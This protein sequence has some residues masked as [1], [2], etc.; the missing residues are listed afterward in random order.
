MG[1]GPERRQ[2]RSIRLPGCD[3]A[4]PGAYFVT[5]CAH[6]KEC[7]FDL[8]ELSDAVEEAWRQIPLHFPN[9]TTDEF[10]VMPNHIHGIL[11]IL[12][13]GAQPAVAGAPTCRPYTTCQAGL[14]GSHR[15]FLQVRCGQ[16]R[17]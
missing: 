12:T 15:A 11:W 16:T 2:R 4:S 8:P 7:I 10:I 17:Q 14:S 6:G 9:V 3:Y 13:V 1:H 5:I